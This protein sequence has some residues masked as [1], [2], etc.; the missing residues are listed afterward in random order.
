M[1]NIY[2][3]Y[4]ENVLNSLDGSLGLASLWFLY[5]DLD[6][7]TSVT[8]NATDVINSK[9]SNNWEARTETLNK[10]YHNPDMFTGCAFARQVVLPGETIGVA[11]GRGL[12]YG[13]Y[14][15]P[16][17]LDG[18]NSQGG[19][20]VTFLE[21]Q[22]SFVDH[23]IRPWIL[24]VGYKGLV[25]RENDEVRCKTMTVNYLK[26]N[27]SDKKLSVRKTFKFYNVVPNSLSGFTNSQS[28]EGLTY[29]SVN[30]LYDKYSVS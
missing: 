28:E 7:L 16:L 1:G 12:E 25:A 30:F 15:V 19:V 10:V 3:Y 18:R 13:G 23:I 26:R 2:E 17:T 29:T 24:K 14:L 8:Q 22:A 5:F 9:E 6:S 4:L 27:G 11:G 21:T 20:Q